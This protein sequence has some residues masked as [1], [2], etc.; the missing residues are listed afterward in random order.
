MRL[1]FVLIAILISTHPR[2]ARSVVEIPDLDFIRIHRLLDS[3]GHPTAL[4]GPGERQKIRIEG[5]LSGVVK[6]SFVDVILPCWFDHG[7]VRVGL[8]QRELLDTVDKVSLVL[9]EELPSAEPIERRMLIQGAGV[10]GQAFVHVEILRVIQGQ[11]FLIPRDLEVDLLTDR[12]RPP[13]VPIGVADEL[14]QRFLADERTSYLVGQGTPK[15]WISIGGETIGDGAQ[16]PIRVSLEPDASFITIPHER[17]QEGGVLAEDSAIF[18]APSPGLPLVYYHYGLDFAEL[19]GLDWPELRALR[20]HGPACGLLD[21]GQGHL[22]VDRR[23]AGWLVSMRAGSG[24]QLSLAIGDDVTE[25]GGNLPLARYKS[26]SRVLGVDS[27]IEGLNVLM[28][29]RSIPGWGLGPDIREKVAA[30]IDGVV[31]GDGANSLNLLTYLDDLISRLERDLTDWSF[32]ARAE[33]LQALRG[34]EAGFIKLLERYPVD[35]YLWQDLSTIRWLLQEDLDILMV[36]E[37]LPPPVQPIRSLGVGLD[38]GRYGIL[39]RMRAL[40]AV[41]LEQA[42]RL[43]EA[44]RALRDLSQKS[45][46]YGEGALVDAALR[47]RGGSLEDVQP[48]IGLETKRPDGVLRSADPLMPSV[49]VTLSQIRVP[50]GWADLEKRFEGTWTLEGFGKQVTTVVIEPGVGDKTRWGPSR[51]LLLVLSMVREHLDLTDLKLELPSAPNVSGGDKTITWTRRSGRGHPTRI[52][53]DPDGLFPIQVMDPSGS[54]FGGAFGL[55]VSSGVDASLASA[56]RSLAEHPIP[57]RG[58]PWPLSPQTGWWLRCD[59]R[60][61]P[62]PGGKT[63]ESRVFDQLR[64]RYPRSDL[65]DVA[66][67][68]RLVGLRVWPESRTRGEDVAQIELQW[69]SASHLRSFPVSCSIRLDK[70][71]H[72]VPQPQTFPTAVTLERWIDDLLEFRVGQ[73]SL[74]SLASGA[75]KLRVTHVSIAD[76]TTGGT[77][78][79]TQ[80]LG[81]LLGTTLPVFCLRGLRPL[82]DHS[83]WWIGFSVDLPQG[84][85][86]EG[87]FLPGIGSVVL[88]GGS[89]TDTDIAASIGRELMG[90]FIEAR[91]LDRMTLRRVFWNYGVQIDWDPSS[92]GAYEIVKGFTRRSGLIEVSRDR[93]SWP[94]AGW[95]GLR[96]VVPL[97][98]P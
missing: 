97:S 93:L 75:V 16:R 61:P 98:R 26:Q 40:K 80:E 92:A 57:E 84:D 19:K 63:L 54:T 83:G 13:A 25:L 14:I 43:R 55:V 32:L 87:L 91:I 7:V 41:T 68:S 79:S 58:L 94:Y 69:D 24:S 73:R 50:G 46:S 85:R 71:P 21:E 42:G 37:G 59:P 36:L 6:G 17:K 72:A 88:T 15:P 74:A 31:T 20:G 27:E 12:V 23:G 4:P 64:Q 39:G 52:S 62:A 33:N 22:G 9:S 30:I 78:Y 44:G 47:L 76:F 1:R 48:G 35:P 51:T 65:L 66:S 2:S 10:A 81:F 86:L 29:P 82:I 3:S 18:K 56:H 53:L 70:P 90:P 95:P 89:V 67:P 96:T 49:A 5:S 34:H 60:P 28:Q 11:S 8:S 38:R 45:S 77:A